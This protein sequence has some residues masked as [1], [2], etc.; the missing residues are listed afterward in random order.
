MEK[1]MW[2]DASPARQRQRITL[3]PTGKKE[4]TVEQLLD[5]A[6]QHVNKLNFP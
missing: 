2:I 5:L 3:S 6:F 4:H 1:A